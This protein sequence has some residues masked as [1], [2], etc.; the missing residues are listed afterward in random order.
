MSCHFVL[1]REAYMPF[2]VRCHVPSIDGL[3]ASRARPGEVTPDCAVAPAY[4]Y[5]EVSSFLGFIIH[6]LLQ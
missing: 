5:A 4:A 2:Y 1:R 3:W 6:L